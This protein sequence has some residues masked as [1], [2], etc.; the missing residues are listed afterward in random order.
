MTVN[1]R[2]MIDKTITTIIV[3]ISM[4]RIKTNGKNMII[5]R[6]LKPALR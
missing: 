4:A 2:R 3:M 5:I 1:K 6:K